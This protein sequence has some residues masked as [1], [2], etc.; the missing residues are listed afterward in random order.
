CV[1]KCPAKR[2]TGRS[3]CI[4]NRLVAG[5]Y[6]SSRKCSC[7]ISPTTRLL[8]A[9]PTGTICTTRHSIL[10]GAAATLGGFTFKLGATSNPACTNSSTSGRLLDVSRHEPRSARG[11]RDERLVQQ[12]QLH[13]P[14]GSPTGRTLPMSPAMVAA[15][16]IT[17][18]VADVREIL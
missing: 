12:P 9:F 1:Y 15:A 5:S 2:P 4:S 16:A 17:G 18:A 11:L 8:G 13:R 10:I 7:T 3:R 6:T 14:Q